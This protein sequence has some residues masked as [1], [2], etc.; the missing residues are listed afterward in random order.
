MRKPKAPKTVPNDVPELK[1]E[2]V[3]VSSLQLDPRN[4]RR[5]PKRNIAD[6]KAALAKFGQQKP[7]VIS[8]A[9]VVIA[10]NGTLAA[11]REMGWEHI[12]IVRSELKGSDA[13]AYAIVDNKT[14]ESSEWDDEVLAEQVESLIEEGMTA[15]D[16]A[17]NEAELEKLIGAPDDPGADETGQLRDRFEVLVVCTSEQQ[18]GEVLARLT[19][20]GYTCRSL[21]S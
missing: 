13:T 7:I 6:I 17:F 12:N 16:L 1:I 4:A 11:A 18:Q 8:P 5:H 21:I 9:G 20:E 15:E 2:R 10:G 19:K 3:L 14:A